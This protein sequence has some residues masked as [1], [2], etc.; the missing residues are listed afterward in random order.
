MPKPK[1]PGREIP[2]IKIQKGQITTRVQVQK[3]N[4]LPDP[5]VDISV[6][7]HLRAIKRS[8]K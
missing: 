2:R 4:I 5:N 8:R 6:D 3:G 1:N 7:D